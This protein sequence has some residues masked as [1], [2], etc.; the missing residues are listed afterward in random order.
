[1]VHVHGLGV[2]PP[3]AA[4][5]QPPIRVCSASTVGSVLIAYDSTGQR[6]L[7]SD[8]GYQQDVGASAEV[9]KQSL[10]NGDTP[11]AT[12]EGASSIAQSGFP[13]LASGPV[14]VGFL[15]G[16]PH[17][18]GKVVSRAAVQGNHDLL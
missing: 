16:D 10:S 3:T 12:L 9:A 2:N 8:D 6:V 5:T 14:A 1:M 13:F 18:K 4:S 15:A 7:A 11:P 17:V